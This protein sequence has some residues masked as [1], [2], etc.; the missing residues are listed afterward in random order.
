MTDEQNERIRGIDVPIRSFT[1]N[2]CLF[3]TFSLAQHINENTRR[4]QATGPRN[5]DVGAP[6]VQ[7]P[8]I[9]PPNLQHH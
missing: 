5:A 7:C 3:E 8:G 6:V 1:D 9:I 4:R 2:G